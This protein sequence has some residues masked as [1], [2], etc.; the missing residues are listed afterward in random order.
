L[1]LAA[2]ARGDLPR[3]RG[4]LRSYTRWLAGQAGQ[5]GPAGR[6]SGPGVLPGSLVFA[7]TTNVV[8]LDG[9]GDD[10]FA[11]LDPSWELVEPVPFRPALARVLRGFAL[12]LMAGGH[13]HPWPTTLDCDGITITLLAMCG[14]PGDRGLLG[15]A[16]LLEAELT[17]AR[18]GLPGPDEARLIGDLTQGVP[19]RPLSHRDAL[20]AVR[21]LTE[22]ARQERGRADWL[23]ARLRDAETA[24]EHGK[25]L[26]VE[27]ARRQA[28]L[29]AIRRS[30]SF[31]LGRLITFP[32]RLARRGRTRSQGGA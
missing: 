5:A 6:T 26:E 15:A 29:R 13:R 8:V 11:L 16:V 2:C 30:A 28:Q 17:A 1:V 22:E 3:L 9:A 24:I 18:E 27:C 20:R 4:L 14:Y 23:D 31:R 32:V 7:D 21:R 25:Q 12:R 10:R 19:R